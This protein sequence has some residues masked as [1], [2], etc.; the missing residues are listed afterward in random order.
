MEEHRAS[1]GG[2]PDDAAAAGA[3]RDHSVSAPARPEIEGERLRAILENTGALV[4]YS[5]PDL[6]LLFMNA[7]GRRL[8]GWTSD[9]DLSARPIDTLHPAWATAIIRDQGIPTTLTTGRWQGET[10]IL[11]RDGSEIPVSQIITAHRGPDGEVQYI[12][13]VMRDISRPP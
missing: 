13:T 8:L 1:E 9:E 3:A 6:R 11:R 5:T 4:S 10:A 7:A 12:S 2:P